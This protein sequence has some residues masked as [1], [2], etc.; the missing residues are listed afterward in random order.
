[1]PIKR[2]L[3][4]NTKQS[5][6]YQKGLDLLIHPDDYAE[7]VMLDFIGYYYVVTIRSGGNV[8]G[9]NT[10]LRSMGIKAKKDNSGF[11]STDEEALVT[12][13]TYLV[14]RNTKE[15]FVA[16]LHN[17]AE[18]ELRENEPSED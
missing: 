6:E 15:F 8:E 11:V 7:Q 5:P 18:R 13:F 12:L 17:R 3:I 1:M 10:F 2:E 16:F 14:G 4:E 9:L